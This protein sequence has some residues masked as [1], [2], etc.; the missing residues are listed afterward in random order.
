MPKKAYEKENV[1][2]HTVLNFGTTWRWVV[3]L[4]CCLLHSWGRTP[5]TNSIQDW[6][7]SA[8]GQIP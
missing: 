3:K 6:G 2:L 1:Q 5:C 8:Q 4:I 7:K